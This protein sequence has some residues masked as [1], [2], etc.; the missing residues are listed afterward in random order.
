MTT[1]ADRRLAN[2]RRLE[3]IQIRT[4][5]ASRDWHLIARGREHERIGAMLAP[6]TDPVAICILTPD[7]G[8]ADRDFLIYAHA[9]QVFLLE[10]LARAYDRI[11]AQRAE[12]NRLTA[13]IHTLQCRMAGKPEGNYAAEC[14]MRCKDDHLFRRYLIECHGLANATDLERV[15]TKVRSVLAI[16]SRKELN[17]D[18][19][20]CA[21]WK[22]LLAD[23]F[24]WRTAP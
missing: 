6:G 9:D 15:E 23:Y 7:C 19:A 18:L 8:Y 14:A 22:D 24:K 2:A 5:E 16:S 4:N 3:Q 21:R 11:R 10:L 13:E 20:A 12:I 17:E 1:D